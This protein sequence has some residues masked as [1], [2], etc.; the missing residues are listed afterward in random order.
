MEKVKKPWFSKTLLVNAV[1]AILAV[2]G[3]TE[4]L[5]MSAD[6]MMMIL[7]GINILLRLVT[8][9]KIGLEE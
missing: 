6:K 4:K 9:D 5:D 7:S 3:M 1:M 2:S 8:K